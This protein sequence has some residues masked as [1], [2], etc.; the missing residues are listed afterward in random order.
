M[1][2]DTPVHRDPLVT[3]QALPPSFILGT[4]TASA[5]VEGA[6][7]IG[8]RT[9][10]VWDRFAAEPGRILDGSTTAVTADHYYRYEE[11]VR[12]MKEL[13]TDA[14]RLS[15]GWTRLQPEGTG[16]LDAGGV[17]FYDRLFDEPCQAG[18]SPFVTLSHWD[19]PVQYEGGW[20]SRD[21]AKRL[22]DFAGLVAQRFAD[23]VDGW[24]TINE[25]ATVTLN[26]YA[27]GIHAPG[28]P[29]LFDSL[30]TVHNQ[31]LGHGLAAQALRAAGVPGQIGITN[32]HTPVVPASDSSEDAAM[33]Q[34]FDIVHNR[35]FADPVLLGHYPE[36]PDYLGGIL[37][38][39]TDVPAGDLEII[40]TPL[41]FYGL[42]YYMPTR[43]AAG[44]GSGTSP[45]GEAEAMAALPFRLEAFPE[46]P[47]TGFGWPVAP[48]FFAVAL[49]EVHER[50]G[51]RLPP[52]YITENGA[53][54]ADEVG[55]DGKVH[56]AQRTAY[57][58]RLARGS[59]ALATS[60]LKRLLHD[61][62]AVGSHL[63]GFFPT[64]CLPEIEGVLRCEVGA[65]CA[66]F[67]HYPRGDVGEDGP[68]STPSPRLRDVEFANHPP[69]G[70]FIPVGG[71]GIDLEVDESD[72]LPVLEGHE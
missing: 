63:I 20:L 35:V 6:T 44:S 70:P 27:L 53:S 21:T 12:A 34:L 39:L 14:Y 59:S 37:D 64:Q 9:P 38:V 1:H 47:T 72:R 29:L 36:V 22:G 26:G 10:S 66:R 46:Y 28:V 42:N 2:N 33:A 23:R 32:V 8:R 7:R 3:A 15:L 55:E 50:Y 11:D 40:S 41:D 48:E 58:A 4:A 24:I 30:P 49:K 18:I 31:L 51:D 54:F 56:D 68:N 67:L 62:S 17:D 19:I 57:L 45:D 5:Q 71:F 69:A 61:D 65:G 25:P 52:I 16:P 13:G 60:L 43:V